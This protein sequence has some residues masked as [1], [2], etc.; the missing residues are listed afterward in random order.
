[1][2]MPAALH[3]TSPTSKKSYN[4]PAGDEIFHFPYLYSDISTELLHWHDG[5]KSVHQVCSYASVR[6]QPEEH[7]SRHLASKNLKVPKGAQL[8]PEIQCAFWTGVWRCRRNHLHNGFVSEIQW[9]RSVVFPIK[10]FFFSFKSVKT[11]QHI[12]TSGIFVMHRKISTFQSTT[13][14]FSLA[15]KIPCFSGRHNSSDPT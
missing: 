11:P 8:N 6:P 3:A 5:N 12:V 13:F 4:H 2:C 7:F 15:S 9:E 14:F 1:M 10:L